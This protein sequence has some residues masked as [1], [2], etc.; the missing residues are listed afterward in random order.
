[1]KS[2]I[3]LLLWIV[4]TFVLLAQTKSEHLTFKG[5]PIDGTLNEFVEKMKQCGFRA[6]NIKEN[7]TKLRKELEKINNP[8]VET[9]L[10]LILALSE[11][12]NDNKLVKLKGDFAGYRNCSVFVGVLEYKD[13]VDRIGVVFPECDLWSSLSSNYFSLKEM[14]IQ[15]YGQ[16]SDCTEKFQSY[17]EP[18]NDKDRIYE[19]RMGRCEYNAIWQIEKG[20]ICLS[21]Q[22]EDRYGCFVALRYIDKINSEIMKAEAM[23]DL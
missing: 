8:E 1:M 15:K 7:I 13:L 14:L 16:P 17:S 11:A 9:V 5:I 3:L 18:T 21:I 22:Y 10:N 2:L 20:K 4:N 12:E 19:V 23:N 6:T